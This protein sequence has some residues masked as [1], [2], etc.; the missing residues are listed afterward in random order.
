MVHERR[1]GEPA[2]PGSYRRRRFEAVSVTHADTHHFLCLPVINHV[3]SV[4]LRR[5]PVVWI[6]SVLLKRALYPRHCAVAAH[7]V[8]LTRTGRVLCWRRRTKSCQLRVAACS[9][10]KLCA[11]LP[12]VLSLVAGSSS[13]G[14]EAEPLLFYVTALAAEAVRATPKA[15]VRVPWIMALSH[16]GG[17]PERLAENQ[18]VAR[19]FA[20]EHR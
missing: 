4:P 18:P 20:S 2:S 16:A 15:P 17:I 6:S 13:R 11:V 5:F 12:K 8:A 19:V 7:A 14:R 1:G 10:G 3:N 9:D